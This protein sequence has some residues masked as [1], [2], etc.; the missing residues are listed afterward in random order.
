MSKANDLRGLRVTAFEAVQVV[1]SEFNDIPLVVGKPAWVRVYLD[2]EN[3]PE[4]TEVWGTLRVADSRS[5]FLARLHSEGCA[6]PRKQAGFRQQRLDWS[7]TLNFRLTRD[8]LEKSLKRVPKRKSSEDSSDLAQASVSFELIRAEV[9][10]PGRR[11]R[12]IREIADQSGFDKIAVVNGPELRCRIVFFKHR[13]R[14]NVDFL[15]PTLGESA[16]IRRFVESA[17][18]AGKVT[19]SML[20]VAA[21]RRFMALGPVSRV[22]ART[23]EQVTR[24]YMRFF[25]HLLQLREQD[26]AHGRDP[27]TL[28]LGLM[29]DPSGRFGGA[30]MDSPQFAAPHVVALTT[31]DTDGQL[32]AHELA[33]VLGR[34]H[35]GVPNKAHHGDRIGQ[36]KEPGARR[37]TYTDVNYRADCAGFISARS[38]KYPDATYVGLDSRNRGAEP[39]LLAQDQWFDL[40]TYRY[41]KWVSPVTYLGLLQR[42][43]EI[44][45]EI[46]FDADKILDPQ[47]GRVKKNPNDSWT[48]I[49]E[50]DLGQR[51]GRIHYLGPS[52][53]RT[54][55]PDEPKENGGTDHLVELAWESGICD[56]AGCPVLAKE[57]VHIR[58]FRQLDGSGTLGVF[59]HTLSVDSVSPENL[60]S[61]HSLVSNNG[62]L[63]LIVRGAV[64]DELRQADGREVENFLEAVAGCVG[65]DLPNRPPP[66]YSGNDDAANFDPDIDGDKASEDAIC[67]MSLQYCI[68]DGGYYLR[69]VWPRPGE[70]LKHV[71]ITTSISCLRKRYIDIDGS[72][73]VEQKNLKLETVAVSDRLRGRI[74]VSPVFFDKPQ[75]GSETYD[76]RNEPPRIDDPERDNEASLKILSVGKYVKAVLYES[77]LP[78]T[79]ALKGQELEICIGIVVGFRKQEIILRKTFKISEIEAFGSRNYGSS[80]LPYQRIFRVDDDVYWYRDTGSDPEDIVADKS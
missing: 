30:A 47:N 29:F 68:D 16:A 57:P 13:N 49:G 7:Q 42:L 51:S 46:R 70:T 53:Y 5:R 59:Q 21:P 39:R 76:W 79:K 1:Q 34:R 28:Y 55:V 31:P 33:H 43:R 61:F 19:W 67:G 71:R 2:S 26:I 58:N 20:T 12:V 50:Y 63:K 32:G 77:D 22:S 36:K 24:H 15:E 60:E 73:H 27:R 54:P 80:H 78:G 75:Y 17:F 25:L 52:E 35:P 37:L 72:E 66:A 56:L 9:E 38:A 6:R 45:D 11:R 8:A 65:N 14:E 62:S 4:G 41:P 64:V 10:V 40:M 69:Y 48:V 74:W 3:L 44:D 23:E 18:P